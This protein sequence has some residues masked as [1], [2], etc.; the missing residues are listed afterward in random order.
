MAP[1]QVSLLRGITDPTILSIQ[2]HYA[3]CS[4]TKTVPAMWLT[5]NS[6][7]PQAALRPFEIPPILQEGAAPWCY[8]AEFPS[9][10]QAQSERDRNQ[11]PKYLAWRALPSRRGQVK[12]SHYV[13]DP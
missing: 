12:S 2:P 10:Q 8:S 11:Y 5:I 3:L 9:A 6:T 7:L 1:A 13:I 4:G